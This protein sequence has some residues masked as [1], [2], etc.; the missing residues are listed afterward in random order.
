MFLLLWSDENKY[1]LWFQI[2]KNEPEILPLKKTF[3]AYLR[4]FIS[5]NAAA[6]YSDQ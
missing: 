2:F 4:A 3:C 6:R 1:T 5:L